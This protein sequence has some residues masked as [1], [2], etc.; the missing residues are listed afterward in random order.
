MRTL[1][2]PKGYVLAIALCVVAVPLALRFDIPSSAF[3][4]AAMTTSLFAGRRPAILAAAILTLSFDFFFLEPKH[5]LWVA[6]GSLVRFLMFAGALALVTVLIDAKRRSDMQR[7]QR[8][9]DFRSLAE[10]SPDCILIANEDLHIEFANPAVTK[11]LGYTTNDVIGKPVDFLLPDLAKEQPPK[12]EF[13]A[14]EKDGT[15]LE[16]EATCGRFEGKTTIFLRDITDRKRAQRA[17]EESEENL[18]LTLDTIPGLVFTRSPDGTLEY[19]NR[20]GTEFLGRSLENLRDG[21]WFE[22]LH[23]DERAS[24]VAVVENGFATGQSYLLE[25]RRKRFDG[26]YHWFQTSVHPLRN[27]E[28]KVVR[29]YGL[30]TDIDD[31]RRMEDSLRQTE[32]RLAQATQLA[33]AAELSASIVHE[34]SQPIAAM[35]ANGQACLR[36]MAADPPNVP[37]GMTAVER[38]VRDGKDAREIIKGLRTL[39]KRSA[40]EMVPLEIRKVVDEVALLT[41]GRMLRHNVTFNLQVRQDLPQVTG[42]RVQLQQVLLNLVT[43]AIDAMDKN[44]NGTKTL[45]IQSRVEDGFLLTEV[46]DTGEGIADPDK[47]FEIFFTTKQTGMGVG[48]AIC[49]TIIEAHGGRLWARRGDPTGAVISFTIPCCATPSFSA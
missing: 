41:R 22:T 35:V 29:W 10:T 27:A 14:A 8:E 6:Q 3:L 38:I 42:D 4:L 20:H 17:L 45:T 30:L 48:L 43:N 15:R 44:E 7:L 47:I 36:W 11:M 16:V 18:R 40:P 24:V 32:S 28:G 9:R 21:G 19:V 31:R 2:E 46:S 39:F 23:P 1:S 33:T 5:H 25:C 37:N 34:I 26:T 12:G 49:K 13:L